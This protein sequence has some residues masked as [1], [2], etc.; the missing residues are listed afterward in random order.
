MSDSLAYFISFRTYGTW[1]SGDPRGAV[2][3]R[4]NVHGTPKLPPDPLQELRHAKR[5]KHPPLFLSPSQRTCV[6]SAIREVAI[7]RRWR[8]LALS[9]RTNHIHTVVHAPSHAPERVLNDFKAR[10]TRRLR[11]ERLID[12]TREIWA[13]H[14]STP[15]LYEPHDL[16]DAIDYVLNRQD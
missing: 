5:L 3:R 2:D 15:Q 16:L 6:E 4:H 13:V 8:I 10:A 1:L 7:H 9:A 14:G 11:E 12:P